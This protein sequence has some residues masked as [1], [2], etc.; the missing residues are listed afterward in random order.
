MV[1]QPITFSRFLVHF[2]VESTS[3]PRDQTCRQCH[4][5][6]RLNIAVPFSRLRRLTWQRRRIAVPDLHSCLRGQ[7]CCLSDCSVQRWIFVDSGP[8]IRGEGARMIPHASVKC[9]SGSEYRFIRVDC[10]S[11]TRWNHSPLLSKD[12]THRLIQ[13]MRTQYGGR[14][15]V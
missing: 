10:P 2:D 8:R 13:N 12:E 9:G 15:A 7:G 14:C 6:V 4:D 3:W 1:Y 5:T 11:D